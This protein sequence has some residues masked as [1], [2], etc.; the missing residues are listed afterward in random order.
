MP[1]TSPKNHQTEA[2]RTALPWGKG[3]KYTLPQGGFCPHP[4][5]PAGRGGRVIT[6]APCAKKPA[7]GGVA[8]W[9][10]RFFEERLSGLEERSRRGRPA[11]FSPLVVVAVKAVAC[12]LPEDP[13]GGSPVPPVRPRHRPNRG[14]ARDRGIELRV[15]HL[16][17]ARSRCDPSLDLPVVD[18]PQ[19]PGLRGQSPGRPRPLRPGLRGR[20]VG[21]QRVCDLGRK[22]RRF[23]PAADATRACLQYRLDRCVSSTN[24]S[25]VEPC[26]IWQP[27]MSIAPRSSAAA[28]P[29]PAS[30]PR[31]PGGPGHDHGALRLRQAGVLGGWTTARLIVGTPPSAGLEG[32]LAPAS[33]GTPGRA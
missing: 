10:K 33:T 13:F 6:R 19:G 21:R 26:S 11:V 8:M 16:A 12:E 2:G 28:K 22:R 17:L 30:N 31:P 4:N 24:T 14:R 32:P 9:R 29:T 15:H 7:G 23:R 5:L 1:R 3:R 20:V 25:A 27:G 18:L